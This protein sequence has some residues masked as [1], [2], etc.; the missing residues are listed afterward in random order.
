MSLASSRARGDGKTPRV[1]RFPRRL[2]ALP[3]PFHALALASVLVVAALST[4]PG[5]PFFSDEGV[6]AIQAEQL[7]ETGSWIY[8]NPVAEIDPDGTA[9]PFPQ[10]DGGEK[11][12][13]PYARHPLYP[14]L[15]WGFHA[16]AGRAGFVFLSIVGTV[17]AALLAGTI[18]RLAAAAL[19]RPVLWVTGVGSP[20]LFDSLV[21]FAHTLG[22]A[23]SA[24]AVLAFLRV[25]DEDR[26]RR[27][28]W[29]AGLAAATAAAAALRTEAIFVGPGLAAAALAVALSRAASTRRVVLVALVAVAGTVAARI[30]EWVF[31]RVTLG[32]SVG[33]PVA[34]ESYWRGRGRGFV[35]TWLDP[36]DADGPGAS[37]LVLAFLLL[38]AGAL[39]GRRRQLGVVAV[40]LLAAAAAAYVVRLLVAPVGLVPGLLI[41]FPVGWA[42]ICLIARPDVR[43]P[44]TLVC[45][46]TATTVALGVL[47]TQYPEG[48]SVEFGGRYFAVIVPIAAV[49]LVAGWR[50][51]VG[52]SGSVGM[53]L[54]GAGAVA[55]TVIIV[56]ALG[57]VRDTHGRTRAFLGD[58][59]AVRVATGEAR[60]IVVTTQTLLPQLA[61]PDFADYRWLIP[62]EAQLP[63][64]A[65]RAARA[66]VERLVI[67]APDL[68]RQLA[69]VAPYYSV[70]E[71]RP[72]WRAPVPMAVVEN[73]RS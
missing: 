50:R 40:A 20:L 27:V 45:A 1:G 14:V 7:S 2:W 53:A 63:D 49:P 73:V 11:G 26:R 46:V 58:L 54:V 55:T 41:A 4:R 48:G 70:A 10:G 60:P 33:I 9:M 6:A 36:S 15:L 69:H 17:A 16:I 35:T 21:V 51:A 56:L 67:V 65:A 25:I 28:V 42:G 22:A 34:R 64:L 13:A 5:V 61:W 37:V 12:R 72:A 57:I 19:A 3:L 39:V 23:A 68:E 31:L 43:D 8:P 38:G 59:R 66:G 32:A 71:S 18:A 24:F 52:E 30:A 62:N 47:L 44:V 29:L